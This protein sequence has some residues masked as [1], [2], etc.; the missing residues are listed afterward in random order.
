DNGTLIFN[1]GNA[2]TISNAIG[3]SGA[4]NQNGSGATTFSVANGYT[5]LTT[6]NAGTLVV[7]NNSA[8]GG[9][10]TGTTVAG[11]ILDIQANIGLEPITL[12]GGT[13]ANSTGTG[14][15]SGNITLSAN[16]TINVAGTFSLSGIISGSYSVTK[17]GIGSLNLS[18]A[19]NYVGTT[20]INAGTVTISSSGTLGATTNNLTLTGTAILDLQKSLTVGNL[21]MA[22]GNTITNSTGTSSLV[23]GG[24]ASL[25]GTITT[26]GDQSF[27]GAVT[28]LA[29]TNLISNNGSGNGTITFSNTVDSNTGTNYSLATTTGTGSTIFGG[30]VGNTRALLSLLTSGDTSVAASVTT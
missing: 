25:A 15:I 11:G 9:T 23:V 21:V 6:V 4:V 1:H 13:L 22:S 18:G 2:I 3:G 8:L 5:G 30:L 26:K 12:S 20:T 10:S 29:N 28:L 16:S 24:T 17:E 27:T 19:N 14:A 7:T